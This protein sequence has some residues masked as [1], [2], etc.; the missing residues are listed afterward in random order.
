V[1]RYETIFIIKSGV[2]EN[3]NT[4]IIDRASSIITADGGTIFK[5]DRWGL[6]KLAYLIKKDAQGYYVYMDY[7]S[8]PAA[9]AEMERI[10][11]IDDRLIK[12]MTVKLA[13]SCDPAAILEEI[14]ARAAEAPRETTDA[15]ET[16][17]DEADAALIDAT[18]D[19]E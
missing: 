17:D 4:E 18:D 19:D 13:D 14:A 2:G 9:V 8:L 16:E 12:F 5:I 3:E 15:G 7:G 11:K 10:F 6:K 1:R